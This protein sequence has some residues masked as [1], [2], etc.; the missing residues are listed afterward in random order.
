ML[1]ELDPNS[2]QAG[3]IPFFIVLGLLIVI[4][5]GYLSMRRHLRRIKAPTKAELAAAR[6]QAAHPE[7][8]SP[9]E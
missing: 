7:S 3:M 9:S 6:A 8:D 2:V 5:L 4:A 1:L